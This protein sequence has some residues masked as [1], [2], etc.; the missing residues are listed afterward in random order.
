MDW[1]NYWYNTSEYN[2]ADKEEGKKRKVLLHDTTLRDGTQCE[3][4]AFS[5]IA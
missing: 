4:I 2:L 1:T 5:C 3:G